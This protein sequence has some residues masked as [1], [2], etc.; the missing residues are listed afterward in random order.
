M[1]KCAPRLLLVPQVVADVLQRYSE[2]PQVSLDQLMMLSAAVAEAAP[3]GG[4]PLASD[5]GA[6]GSAATNAAA[7]PDAWGWTDDGAVL[8]EHGCDTSGWDAYGPAP[9]PPVSNAS[10]GRE[11]RLDGWSEAEAMGAAEKLQLLIAEFG[12]LPPGEVSAA[13]AA[14]DGG[15][16]AAAQLLR[17]MAEEEKGER[18]AG[19]R[20][21][22]AAAAT[23]PAAAVPH[24]APAHGGAEQA[25]Q[26]GAAGPGV[27]QLA[28]RFPGASREAL[29]VG[30]ACWAGQPAFCTLRAAALAQLKLPHP[31]CWVG[32]DI[33]WF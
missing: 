10:N 5:G 2:T 15:L 18:G 29:E 14:C 12:S 19:S 27:S 31:S 1:G 3:D 23:V 11:S 6:E 8:L 13:L 16:M 26:A 24:S 32:P 20:G 28:Q 30:A 4:S 21:A 9:P 33:G 7:V 22:A 25:R 17:A